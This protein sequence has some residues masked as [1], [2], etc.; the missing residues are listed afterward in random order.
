MASETRKIEKFGILKLL[1]EDRGANTLLIT[2]DVIQLPFSEYVNVK[3]N[4]F[5]GHYGYCCFMFG[6]YVRD[7]IPLQF[8]RQLLLDRNQYIV[9]LAHQE[10]HNSKEIIQQLA[11]ITFDTLVDYP[12]WNCTELR[13]KLEP[14]VIIQ[15][16]KASIPMVIAQP[17]GIE[18]GDYA[19]PG[20]GIGEPQP[21]PPEDTPDDEK[22][23]LAP[24]YEGEDDS[25]NTYVRPELQPPP[26]T[27][28]GDCNKVYY[29]NWEYT[30]TFEGYP[31]DTKSGQS[32][33]FGG[34]LGIFAEGGQVVLKSDRTAC[35]FGI[36]RNVLSQAP[37]AITDFSGTA[38]LGP[39]RP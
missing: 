37:F 20:P 5:K 29:V 25:G 17:D 36:D 38:T 26:D 9:Q 21:P 1:P 8:R 16:Y 39:E 11:D 28:Q 34:F 31:P 12:I 30:V 14:G 18:Q 35:G 4:P 33:V 27:P 24:P 32:A 7:M 22:I 15:V 6:E 3:S 19:P 2:C 13:F 10:F 23:A